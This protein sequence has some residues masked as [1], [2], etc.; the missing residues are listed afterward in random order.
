MR[1]WILV[2][3]ILAGCGA[4]DGL[5]VPGAPS[6]TPAVAAIALGY[7]HSCALLDDGT[8]WCWGD[9]TLGQLGGA[10]TSTPRAKPAAL[11]SPTGI[12][13][14]SAG[15]DATCAVLHDGTLECWGSGEDSGTGKQG[16]HVPPTAIAGGIVGVSVG[17]L[18][19][20]AVRDDGGVACWGGSYHGA[21]GNGDPSVYYEPTPTPVQGVSGS[22]A[23]AAGADL[24]CAVLAGGAVSCWGL[25]P[26][27]GSHLSKTPVAVKGLAGPA[28]QVVVGGDH[29]CA[30]LSDASVMCWGDNLYGQLGLGTG[31][32]SAP[33]PT[34]VPGLPPVKGISACDMHSCA[35][36]ADGTARCWGKDFVYL[37]DA[38]APVPVPGLV[39]AVALASGHAHDCALLEDG[40]V[41]C[42]GYNPSGQLGDGTMTSSPTPVEV[43]GL[44]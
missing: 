18:H 25:G 17:F 40:R 42:W 3:I 20:C 32:A 44:P 5:P 38:F 29:A 11:A 1:R 19:G 34:A 30:L 7:N 43:I 27:D 15:L 24:T 8:A 31:V 39:G 21:L 10:L 23:V 28:E 22:V 13:S 16:P 37:N 6:G 14:M 4:S 12:T 35:L 2:T 36:L 9:D 26:G 41:V 33:L